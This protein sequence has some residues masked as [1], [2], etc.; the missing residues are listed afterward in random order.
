MPSNLSDQLLSWY[1]QS[2]RSLP[3]RSNPQ[4]YPVWVSE[5]MLQQTRVETVIPYF[6]RWMAR[7]PDIGALAR[8]PL[9]E[10]LSAWEG[11]GYYSRARSLHKSA[12]IILS[13]YDGKLP[14][15][16]EELK[17]LPGIG[18]YT[19]AAILS[20]AYGLDVPAVDSNIRRVYSRL[21]DIS[22]PVKSTGFETLVNNIAGETLPPGKAGDF[23]QALMDLGAVIC[24]PASPRCAD[25]PVKN[26]C[27]A[28]NHGTQDKR[29][30]MFPKKATPFFLVTA[31]VIWR[32]NK[33]LIARRPEKGLLG[34]LWEF[35]GGKVEA[36]ESL[37]QALVREI[38][39]ELG[40]AIK[41]GDPCG[42][43]RHAYTHFRIELH[44]FLCE[45][46]EGEPAALHASEIRWVEKKV[47]G[48][49]PMGK[50]DRLISK[51]LQLGIE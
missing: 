50:V 26:A 39:E 8:A 40:A 22:E 32:D 2:G 19:A 28:F 37:P 29:P 51:R 16:L 11:L 14:N 30:V 47:L 7:F 3:W 9:Q 27:Q 46:Q 34:G 44:A 13:D 21:F 20:I 15:Q 35:P 36:D 10:I 33:V 48:D 49:F 38:H 18:A 24:L 25:C 12:Q 1:Y 41:V 42:V 17:R 31:A 6:E 43:F 5:I 4:P 23:N 45:L